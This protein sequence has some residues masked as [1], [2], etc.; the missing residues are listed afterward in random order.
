MS[1]SSS[2]TTASSTPRP[3]VA[4]L[5]SALLPGVGQ[6]YGGDRRRGRNLLLVD[7]AIL[8]VLLFFFNDT[9]SIATA[10]VRPTTLA[11]LMVFNIVLLG[12]RV[13]AADDAYRIAVGRN[14]HRVRGS[15]AAGVIALAALGVVLLTPHVVFGYYDLVQYQFLNNTFGSDSAATTTVA[16]TTSPDS[17]VAPPVSGGGQ[18]TTTTTEPVQSTSQFLSGLDRLN[19]LLLGGDFGAGRSGVRTDTMIAVSI[20]PE[21]GE[22]AMFSVPR[23]WTHAPLPAGMGIWDCDC[24]PELINELWVMGERHPEAFPGPGTPS[25]NAVK[26]VISEFLGIDIHYYALVNLDGFVDIIDAIGGVDI[27][28]PSRVI[29]EEYPHE[30]GTVERIDIASGWQKLDGHLALA[31]ARTRHQDSDYFRMNRQRCVIEA[32]LE[33]TDPT[34]LIFNFQKL[35]NVIERSMTTDIP[36]EALPQLV[37]LLPKVDLEE[38][39]SISFVPPDYHLK[40]RD[41]G[42]QGRI[43]D[44]GLVHEHVDFVIRDPER[45]VAELGLEQLED[46]CG[47]QAAGA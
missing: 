5:S 17:G 31:Y 9:V 41:D 38:I 2:S 27:Y 22:A 12:Y 14:A 16:P 23:N 3:A 6:W 34:D 33:Q 44:I 40:Y 32:V 13:W 25:E 10:A 43:A 42:G 45:A 29:D 36:L 4:A 47:E 18:E 46:V 30:D 11:L 15:A 8:V 21:T 20:D 28:V 1:A 39:V 26:A 19:I 35:T 37:E 7:A 24:Y